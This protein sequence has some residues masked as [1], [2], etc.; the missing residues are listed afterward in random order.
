MSEGIFK[1]ELDGKEVG[2]FCGTYALERTLAA[3]GANPTE[4]V[5]LIE[6]KYMFF[7]R[8]YM[9]Y[10]AE[11][12][13]LDLKEIEFPYKSDRIAYKWIDS[14]GGVSGDFYVKFRD[15]FARAMGVTDTPAEQQADAR[16]QITTEK[17]S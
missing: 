7:I 6:N 17:K 14:T 15:A 13:A 3:M 1:Y 4:I 2:F 5:E 11:Y 16:P 10:A 9:Y 8:H 12:Y